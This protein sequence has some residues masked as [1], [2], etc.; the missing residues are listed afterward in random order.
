MNSDYSFNPDRSQEFQAGDQAE[1]P[2]ESQI[3]P[4]TLKFMG[5]A[6]ELLDSPAI[7]QF[8]EAE[9]QQ[10][11]A[12]SDSSTDQNFVAPAS[13]QFQTQPD[14]QPEQSPKLEDQPDTLNFMSM[15]RD[16]LNK[17]AIQ[18]SPAANQPTDQ[19]GSQPN[20]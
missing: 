16:L 4:D 20:P 10:D 15:A 12:D 9:Q 2:S 5:M 8:V 6:K 19:P 3:H 14:P 18:Q 11:Q 7:Q 17:S 1:Q 13:Q